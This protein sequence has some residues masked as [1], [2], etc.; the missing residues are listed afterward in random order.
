MKFLAIDGK[1][2]KFMSTLL[3]VLKLNFFWIIFSLPIVTIGTSTIAAYSVS[4]KIAEGTEGK[5]FEDFWGSYKKNFKQG[6]I[7]GIGTLAVLYAIY[8]N[9]EFFNKIENNPIM[10][11]IAAIFIAVVALAHLTYAYPL[12]ARYDNTLK[13][14]LS[15]SRE[16][17]YKYIF[18]TILL[19]IIVAFLCV[20]FIFN[21][22]LMFIGLLIG[23]STIFITISSFAIRIF[24]TIEKENMS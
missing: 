24:R 9:I 23:P 11:L 19:W 21:Y 8:L 7:L 6:L 20:F 18:K 1:L 4:L 16:I 12:L 17:V 10:F 5:I 13:Q 15:N 14:T 22:V 3:D 2:Y